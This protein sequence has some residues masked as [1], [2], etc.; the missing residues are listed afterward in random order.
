[1]KI[2]NILTTVGVAGVLGSTILT[3]CGTKEETTLSDTNV[4]EETISYDAFS[5]TISEVKCQ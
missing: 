1:M 4:E 3:G 2:K 5:Q